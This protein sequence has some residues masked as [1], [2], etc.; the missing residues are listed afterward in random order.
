MARH[1]AE[2]RQVRLK[3]DPTGNRR[4]KLDGDWVQQASSELEG[5]WIRQGSSVGSAVRRTF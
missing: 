2:I 3:P 4:R 5:D 1:I